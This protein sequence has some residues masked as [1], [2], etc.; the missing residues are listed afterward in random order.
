MNKLPSLPR[1]ASALFLGGGVLAVAS[2]GSRTGLFG[3]D[4]L[5][6]LLDGSGRFDGPTRPPDAASDA[7]VKC[8]PGRFVFERAVPQLM[9]VL[10][11]SGS[12]AFAL[13]GRQPDSRGNL[14]P[15]V[16][17]RWKVLHNG[18][19]S[20]ITPFDKT[21]AMGAKFYPEV[22][23]P[24][25]DIDTGC[26]TEVGVGIAPAPGNAKSIL[27]VFDTTG[28]LGGTPTAEALR[29]AAQYLSGARGVAR[30]M[31]LATDG[32]PNCNAGLNQFNC[33]CTATLPNG[34]EVCTQADTGEPCLDDQRTI[35]VVK[36][37]FESQKIPVYVVG[38]GG[39]APR[40]ISVLDNMAVAGG[41]P[42]ATSPRYFSVQT[43]IEMNDA[44]AAISA[45]V[46]KCT[47]LTPSAPTDPSA[48]SVEI[49]GVSI[50]RDPTRTNGWDWVD[51]AYGTLAFFGTA[52]ELASASNP[53]IGGVVRCD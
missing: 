22:E 1:L 50:P 33:I 32:E 6:G 34:T 21:I 27:D 53:T 24:D 46:A 14:P 9:F 37:I 48:I 7:P 28:P 45:S 19:T 30:T 47:Y 35:N 52:C 13:D 29:I 3:T 15:G 51:Q 43:A 11:R 23:G 42:K 36:G 2:C 25:P 17:S 16:L 10:D 18:L 20:A 38:I 49:G 31:I 41:R 5:G 26:L 44:L 8:T 12:M 39:T 40:I 4:D